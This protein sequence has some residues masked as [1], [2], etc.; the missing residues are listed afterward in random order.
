[1][2]LN[3]ELL[4]EIFSDLASDLVDLDDDA[5]KNKI[6]SY[7]LSPEDMKELFDT[8]KAVQAAEAE[9]DKNPDPLS[10]ENVDALAD[11]NTKAQKMADEDNS[12]VT[13][14]EEDKDDDGDPDKV[15]IEKE[16]PED[17]SIIEWA[18]N[19]IAESEDSG[20]DAK[21]GDNDKPHDEKPKGVVSDSTM[22]NIISTLSSFRR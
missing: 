9:A 19:K 11:A 6:L 3:D 2:E 13:V 18:K 17:D 8:V 12:E 1:M 15:T 5:I 21:L 10:L 20:K 16:S 14:T 22:K 7:G 4:D